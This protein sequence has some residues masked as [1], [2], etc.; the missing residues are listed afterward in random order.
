MVLRLTAAKGWIKLL[1]I[2]YFIYGVLTAIGLIG[3]LFIWLGLVLLKVSK[4]MALAERGD[5]NALVPI[6]DG[7]S[8]YFTAFGIITLIGLVIGVIALIIYGI[9][10]FS[11]LSNYMSGA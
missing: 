1:G 11:M 3:I 9:I 2:V 8:T 7:I 10:G 6:S 5:T 4:N